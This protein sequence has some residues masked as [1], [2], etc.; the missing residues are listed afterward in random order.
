MLRIAAIVVA[1]V[2]ARGQPV[3]AGDLREGMA[4]FVAGLEDEAQ[5]CDFL[6]SLC[7]GAR[8]SD[9]RAEDTP[10]SADFLAARQGLIADQR[11]DEAVAASEAIEHKRGKRLVC[12]D[13]KICLGIVPRPKPGAKR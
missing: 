5:E 6:R 9:A 10:A 13:E 8:A 11:H 1:L 3:P 2:L 12:F 7:R 4:D